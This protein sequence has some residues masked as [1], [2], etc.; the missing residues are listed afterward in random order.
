MSQPSVTQAKL[1]VENKKKVFF[2][3]DLCFAVNGPY[4]CSWYWTGTS[5]QLRLMW[6]NVIKN[7]CMLFAFEKISCLSC[8]LASPVPLSLPLS[9]KYS[10]VMDNPS[11]KLSGSYLEN[12]SVIFWLRATYEFIHEE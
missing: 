4:S 12:L 11:S 2:Q 10:L 6:G 5:L 8:K 9:L 3:F 7:R 1:I